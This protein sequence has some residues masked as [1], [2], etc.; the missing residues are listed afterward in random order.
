LN[1]PN[2]SNRITNT[3]D[4]INDGLDRLTASGTATLT[5]AGTGRTIVTD[6][7]STYSYTPV[8]HGWV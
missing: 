8:G 4:D 7:T 5:Y 2:L 1:L 6:G 3:Y